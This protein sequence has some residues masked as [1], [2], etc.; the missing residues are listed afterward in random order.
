MRVA[1]AG[2]D[3]EQKGTRGSSGMVIQTTMHVTV[4]R[5]EGYIHVSCRSKRYRRANGERGVTERS[6]GSGRDVIDSAER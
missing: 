1:S 5:E 6:M 3:R 4:R 2:E